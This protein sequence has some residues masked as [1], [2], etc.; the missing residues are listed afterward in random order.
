VTEV[1]DRGSPKGAF[2]TLEV[3]VVMSDRLKCD[4][5]V[6]QVLGPRRAVDQNVIK[7]TRANLRR[8][9]RRTSFISAWNVAGA[10]ASPNGITR[11]S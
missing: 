1:G 5:E 3:E 7:N 6:L 9:G 11:N 10:M 8:Y 4:S 2:G